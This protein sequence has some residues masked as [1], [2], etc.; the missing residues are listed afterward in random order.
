[1]IGGGGWELFCHFFFFYFILVTLNVSIKYVTPIRYKTEIQ[2]ELLSLVARVSRNSIII[3]IKLYR[4]SQ[5]GLIE[6]AE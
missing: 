4:N 3:T 2:H 5:L 6:V 1:M